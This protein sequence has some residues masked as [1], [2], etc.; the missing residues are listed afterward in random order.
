MKVIVYTDQG[1]GYVPSATVVAGPFAT[2]KEAAQE[3]TKKGF[4]PFPSPEYKGYDAR[5]TWINRA[6]QVEAQFAKIHSVRHPNDCKKMPVFRSFEE[7]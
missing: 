2:R 1:G 5:G 4:V 7:E 3:L 6:N